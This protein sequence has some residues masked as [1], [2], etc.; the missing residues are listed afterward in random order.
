MT[1]AER[2]SAHTAS[3]QEGRH[4]CH[5]RTLVGIAAV[6]G[7]LSA[8]SERAVADARRILRDR[9]GE[10]ARS[11]GAELLDAVPRECSMP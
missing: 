7:R 1:E 2:T 8:T 5:V 10:L 4:S 3:S 11:R 6:T 9:R